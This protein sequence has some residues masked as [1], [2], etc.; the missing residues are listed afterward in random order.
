MAKHLSACEKKILAEKK[1]SGKEAQGKVFHL[2]VEG[3]YSPDYWMHLEV[4]ASATLYDIDGF[5]R[6][7]WL[8]CC[9]HLS[10]FII[11]DERYT[12][13]SPFA[14][15]DEIDGLGMDAELG[16]ILRPRMKLYHDYDFGST[17]HL[18]LR[19]VSE[20]E[21]L[22]TGKDVRLLARNE[23]PIYPCHSCGKQATQICTECAYEGT[24]LFCD[25]CATKHECGEE[26]L[27]PVVNSPRVGV[28]GYTG[29][30]GAW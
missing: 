1:S 27:L 3:R 17:T 9:G 11:K 10:E 13:S 14:R 18:T 7:V 30:R 24:G 29:G 26:M 4:P 2:L 28:C 22:I 15:T 8:E 19:V 12:A 5:L 25:D 23:P 16:E 6:D 21:G 20:K